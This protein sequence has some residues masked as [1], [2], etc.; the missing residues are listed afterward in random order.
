MKKCFYCKVDIGKGSV[1]GM[2]YK[3]MYQIWGDKMSKAIISNMEKEKDKGN[4]E[5]GRISELQRQESKIEEALEI[6][7]KLAHELEEIEVQ[8]TLQKSEEDLSEDII[9]PLIS[10]K[11]DALIL[12]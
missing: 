8:E 1:V 10:I 6:S 3:C 12:N 4:L 11:S 2:C 7:D 9:E 5:L